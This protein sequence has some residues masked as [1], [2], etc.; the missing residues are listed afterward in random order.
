[1]RIHHGDRSQL[2]IE[3]L[4]KVIIAKSGKLYLLYRN[5]E[6]VKGIVEFSQVETNSIFQA[7]LGIERVDDE[8]LWRIF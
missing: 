4:I 5:K 2:A 1:M 8:S 6:G 7:R 3:D